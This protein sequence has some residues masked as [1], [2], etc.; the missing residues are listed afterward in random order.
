MR[1]F[2]DNLRPVLRRKVLTFENIVTALAC[3]LC[4]TVFWTA[5][6]LWFAEGL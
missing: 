2:Y 3:L 1:P 5:L 6:L 4:G